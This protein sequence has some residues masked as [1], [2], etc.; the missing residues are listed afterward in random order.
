GNRRLKLAPSGRVGEAVWSPSG[1][2]LI[3][4]HIPDDT[5]ELISLREYA[6]GSGADR[7]VA[8]TSQFARFACNGDASVFAGASRSKA[9]A[10]LLLLL[11]V[12]RRELTLCEHHASDPGMVS[13]VFPPNSQSIFFVTDRHGRPAIY[14]VPVEKF[15]AETGG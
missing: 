10:Y 9:S 3:Y 8:H 14:R 13:P 4:L 1:Q 7:E 5:K 2:T 6:P 11:R 15:V 12:T